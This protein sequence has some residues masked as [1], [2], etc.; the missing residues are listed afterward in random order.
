MGAL[1]DA[2]NLCG[3][4]WVLGAITLVS[5]T[6]CL[7]R[8]R[9]REALQLAA[10]FIPR[11]VQQ[12]IKGIVAAPRPSADLLFVKEFPHDLAYPFGHAVGTT[13]VFVLLFVFA[14]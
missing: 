6:V 1:L 7:G 11:A 13:V 3:G 5:A 12:V 8:G 2:V 4:G 10:S 14:P 9:K